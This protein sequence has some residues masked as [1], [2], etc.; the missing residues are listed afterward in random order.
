[1]SAKNKV[2]L[3]KNGRWAGTPS[4]YGPK[5]ELTEEFLTLA[6]ENFGPYRHQ[7]HRNF[8][9]VIFDHEC[10]AAWMKLLAD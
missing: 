5:L 7:C 9:T 8:I 1:M 3:N 10:D 6:R 4:A 2:R